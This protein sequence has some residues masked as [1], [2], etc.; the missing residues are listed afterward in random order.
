VTQPAH[1][2]GPYDVFLLW[3]GVFEA[4]LDSITHTEGEPARDRA[5]AAWGQPKISIDVNCFAL[6]GPG[7]VTLIDA[8]TGTA[9]GPAYGHARAALDGIAI[10]PGQVDRVLLT[11]VHGDHALGLLGEGD[12]D[13][14]P[15]AEVLVPAADWAFYADPQNRLGLPKA[16]QSAFD[17]LEKLQHA[18]GDRIRPA[19]GADLPPGIDLL[20]MPGHTPGH[21]GYLIHDVAAPLLIWG[22][23]LHV[24]G[25]QAA[26][27]DVG[28]IYDLDG[29]LAARSRHAALDQASREGW[30]VTGG[31]ITGFG[32]VQAAEGG[33]QIVPA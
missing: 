16:R 21:A 20:P 2:F 18:Y 4:P 25:L 14:F 22:D 33:Y 7:G 17:I 24:A 23:V 13:Y 19:S 10:A 3:D 8:G 29:A 11:H 30:I 27:P 15:H 9:W 12:S 6:R 31:H 5:I 26:D 1:R 32:R 28:L